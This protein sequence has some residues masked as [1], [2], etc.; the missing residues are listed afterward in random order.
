M[1]PLVTP[2]LTIQPLRHAD[3]QALHAVYSD[4]DVVRYVPDGVRD[5]AGTRRRLE[6]LMAH[7]EQYGVSKWAV[8]LT[9]SGQ[10][11]GDCGLQFL[12]GTPNLELGFH[13]ARVYWGQGYATEA[14]VACLQWALVHRPEKIVAVV[15]PA[16]LVSQRILSE[17]GMRPI[18]LEQL[19]NR[20]WLVYEVD[21]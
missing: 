6:E 7:H 15:D 21:Q 2:R 20:T 11:I 13:L 12:P 9:S 18:G 8:I 10:V 19:L 14:A 16:H 17:I 5:E 4:P 3:F 1:L